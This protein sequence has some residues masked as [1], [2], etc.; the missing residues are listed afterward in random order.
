[1]ESMTPSPRKPLPNG[2]F[3]ARPTLL[4][5]LLCSASAAL[6]ADVLSTLVPAHPRL[7]YSAQDFQRTRAWAD[8]DSSVRK[9]YLSLRTKGDQILAKTPLVYKLDA[10]DAQ[11]LL[12]VSR[13]ALERIS[14]LAAL[15][16]MDGEARH[17]DGAI[18]AM[19]E[20]SAFPDWHPPHFL[21]VAEM[22][23]A[24]ALGYDWLYQDL[25]PGMR[26]TL[27]SAIARHGLRPGMDAYRNKA[28]GW[29][30]KSTNNWNQVC[31]AGLALGA[32]AIAEDSAALARSILD[33]ALGSIPTSMNSSYAPD[34]G[35][36]EGV[37]YWEYGTT[38]NVYLL[39][40]LQTAL[41]KTFG[42]MEAPGFA[43]TADYRL[44]MVGPTNLRYSYADQSIPNGF[45]GCMFWFAKTLQRP[46]YARAERVNAGSPN[47]FALLWYDPV[48]A[49]QSDTYALP[50]AMRYQNLDV[51]AMRSSW[52]D[53]NAW[54][55]GFKGGDNQA[56]H[57]HLD[58]GSFVL[59]QGNVR[60]AAD[61][62]SDNYGVP[63]YF[64][65]RTL[66]GGAHWQIYRTRTEGHNTL[67]ISATAQTPLSFASQGILAKAPLLGFKADP[68][69]SWAIADLTAGYQAIAT[70]ARKVTRAHRGV[71]LWPGSQFLVQ[72]EVVSS[73]PVEIVWNL[74]TEAVV[75]LQGGTATLSRKGKTMRLEVLSPAGAKF[76]TV[77]CHPP[78]TRTQA[79][80]DAGAL[81]ENPNN[82]FTKVIVRLPLAT[83]S[84]TLAV[85]FV[86]G[87]T[88][89][90][91]PVLRPLSGW[92]DFS[93]TAPRTLASGPLSTGHVAV[94]LA[95]GRRFDLSSPMPVGRHV[96]VQ[97]GRLRVISVR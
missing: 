83:A 28:N 66:Q 3:R 24:V 49:A 33:S 78:D 26:D 74:L 7:L 89:P 43:Q 47:I 84:T 4:A 29:W 14:T 5:S 13:D 64:K 93:S 23:L 56:S 69:D 10:T 94:E 87:G 59:D 67:T 90:A 36:P 9:V 50:L 72:D 79:E 57:G 48:L 95:T 54:Y 62:G 53:P 22:T 42:L 46:F 52:T 97:D 58:L 8:T 85:R 25:T 37:G 63:K 20:V 40:G 45:V 92:K 12:T 71:R 19:K 41:G 11:R 6:G 81:A 21:D 38:Y 80:K 60:W 55:V 82:G 96:L 32:L 75:T 77:T 76:D 86:P 91:A 17:R 68:T 15:Y 61:L 35:F 1:M 18:R 44:Q 27:R 51:V 39:A 31:N 70:D 34:G 73:A 88:S 16:R 30:V 2:H 65:E